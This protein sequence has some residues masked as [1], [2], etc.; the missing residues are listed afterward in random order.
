MNNMC[1]KGILPAEGDFNE[2]G[3]LKAIF[4]ENIMLLI[5]DAGQS[6]YLPWIQKNVNLG[7]QNRDASRNLTYRS[8]SVSCPTGD[9][10]SYEASSIVTFMQ[11]CPPVK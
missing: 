8:Y 9:I 1:N 5:N 2:Q 3:V 7:W 6:Q 10:Q 11:V 4:A